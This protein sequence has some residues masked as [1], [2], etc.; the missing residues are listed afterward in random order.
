M[1]TFLT[2]EVITRFSFQAS[3][4]S[5]KGSDLRD[6]LNKRLKDVDRS[7]NSYNHDRGNSAQH[8]YSNER[9]NSA[10]NSYNNERGNTAPNHKNQSNW[11]NSGK[12]S[13]NRRVWFILKLWDINV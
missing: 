11:Q 7:H 12:F 2:S 1:A 6:R 13:N 3:Y 4:S 10:H 9:G 5:K 8:S